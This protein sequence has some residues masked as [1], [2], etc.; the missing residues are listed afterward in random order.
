M[1][2]HAS[3]HMGDASAF[4]A[5]EAVIAERYR[6]ARRIGKGGMGSVYLAED[7]RLG[8]KW[9]ALKITRPYPEER[10]AFIAE[11]RVLSR[12][13]HPH[14]PRIV[15][16]LPPDGEGL[17]CIVMD[18]VAGETLAD[19][20]ERHGRRLPFAKAIRYLT[21]LAGVLA[22]LHAQTPA[23]VFRDLKPANVIIDG[24]DR[25]VLVDF[26]IARQFRPGAAADTMRLGTP[27]FAAPEQLRGGQTDARTDLYGLGAL[28]Y[29]LLTAGAYAAGRGREGSE[30][31]QDDAPPMFR[32]SVGRLLSER[33]AD[34]P[35]SA[36]EVLRE[37]RRYGGVPGEG[38][39]LRQPAETG[40]TVVALASA[41]PGAGATFAAQML[42]RR[43]ADRDVPHAL[44]ECPGGEPELYRRL[45]GD[46]RMPRRA[47]FADPAGAGPVQPAWR[48]GS[49]MYYPLSDTAA[50][51]APP[52][53]EFGGWLRKLG[54]P[55]VLLD[56]SSRWQSQGASAWLAEQADAIYLVADSM[57]S[58]WSERRQ[59]GCAELL[60]MA[61]ANGAAAGWIA[62]R[63]HAFRERD[64]WLTLFPE[65][66]MLCLPQWPAE[67]VAAALWRGE[68]VRLRAR[69]AAAVDAFWRRGPL[70]EA[71]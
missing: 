18:Y 7:L 53:A 51:W 37:W 41:Y 6:I 3:N 10:D 33:P 52:P 19:R 35:G 5:A 49:A 65:E 60:R 59:R 29:Y 58:K 13:D 50:A 12:L 1:E 67:E 22:Y 32:E 69:E 23:I 38:A 21:H 39:E 34:R 26:G 28:A 24:A 14:L 61:R 43:L 31:W 25:A 44:V 42:S 45:D 54:A 64:E 68:T 46:R 36:G 62:N 30:P 2:G 47:A 71:R 56:V 66:P 70:G 15:D 4:G 17:A 55:V 57:P 48:Q 8:G 9:Q 40:V 27:A 20:F 63:D 16:Y 11:A